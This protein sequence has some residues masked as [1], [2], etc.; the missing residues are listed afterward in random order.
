VIVYAPTI[1][2][3]EEGPL[4]FSRG[5]GISAIAYHGKMDSDT[6]RENQD[7]GCRMKFAFSSAPLLSD[8]GINKAAVRAVIHLSLP[9]I[10]RAILSGKL[11]ARAATDSPRTAV[12]LCRKKMP[13][14][15]PISSDS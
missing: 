8:S 1:N 14:S 5:N 3:V 13:D 6:R 4:I 7:A 2:K 12:V 11:D 15:S 10:N 9:E